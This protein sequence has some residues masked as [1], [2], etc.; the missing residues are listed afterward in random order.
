MMKTDLNVHIYPRA[1]K[2]NAAG[3]FPIYVKV[4][5]ADY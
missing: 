5:S 3:L 2:A 1:A 4:E